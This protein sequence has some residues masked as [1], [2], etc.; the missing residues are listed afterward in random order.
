MQETELQLHLRVSKCSRV[1]LKCQDEMG[2]EL[3][4]VEESDGKLLFS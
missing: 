2:V 3:L 4:C 1:M